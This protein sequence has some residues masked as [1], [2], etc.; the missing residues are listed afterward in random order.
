MAFFSS[1][2]QPEQPDP[3]ERE[4]PRAASPIGFETVLGGNAAMEGVLSSSG[5]VRLDGTF[6]GTLHISGNI[7]VGET[8]KINA[9][10]DA[11]NISIAGAIHGNV[12]GNKVQI[13]RTGRV[14]G[15]IHATA[16]ATEEGA[17]IDGRITMKGHA[18]NVPD[19]PVEKPAIIE[20]PSTPKIDSPQAEITAPDL[21]EP[22]PESQAEET[23]ASR[24]D[25]EPTIP[26][27][28]SAFRRDLP[29][30]SPPDSETSD[31]KPEE[32]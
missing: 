26:F 20:A 29:P 18:A 1:R 27:P 13:L 4:V 25:L 5:N 24:S 7:L 8:A 2:R 19:K 3:E 31:D 9:D 32:S 22:T 15:D 21:V 6:S 28:P 16:L 12:T 23:A 11:R 17:F 14:W 30:F 10:I